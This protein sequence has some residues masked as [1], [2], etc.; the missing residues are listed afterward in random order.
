MFTYI[1]MFANKREFL[2]IVIAVVLLTYFLCYLQQL[3]QRVFIFQR[4]N[5]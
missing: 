5:L 1:Y 4:E 3:I 2:P